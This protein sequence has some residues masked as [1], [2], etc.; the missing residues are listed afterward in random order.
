MRL[1]DERNAFDSGGVGAFAAL[2]EAL[3]DDRFRIGEQ[4]DAFASFAFAA[5]V[6]IQAFAIGGLR[7]HACQRVLAE[8]ARAAKEQRMRNSLAAQSAAEGG[9]DTFIAEKFGEAHGS[10]AF[11]RDGQRNNLQDS[12]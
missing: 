12:G 8:A 1:E 5:E 11:L 4:R 9:D 2:G 10:A 7:E 3:F 6:V